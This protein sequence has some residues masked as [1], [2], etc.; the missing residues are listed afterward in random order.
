MKRK[1]QYALLATLGIITCSNA[2][3]EAWSVDFEDGDLS[4]WTIENVDGDGSTWQINKNG[5]YIGGNLSLT[6]TY[7][8]LATYGHDIST[9]AYF[10]GIQ[11]NWA[12]SPEIDLSFYTGKGELILNA[13]PAIYTN[14][15]DLKVYVSTNPDYLD[16]EGSFELASTIELNRESST[17]PDQFSDYVINFDKYVGEEAIYIAFVNGKSSNFIGYEINEIMLTAEDF[18]LSASD[19]LNKKEFKIIE[20]PVAHS[21]KLQA[22]STVQ[23]PIIHIY[24]MNGVLIKTKVYNAGGIVVSELAKGMYIAEIETENNAKEVIKFIKK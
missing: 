17:D 23:N 14:G 24:N 9:G 7:D 15:V 6:G 18:A 16:L 13:Q 20:N 19:M 2:Q 5:E 12:I 10:P 11:N 21:L 1:V 22:S 4:E 3:Q 8:V